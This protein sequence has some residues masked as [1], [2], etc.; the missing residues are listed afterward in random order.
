[1]DFIAVVVI[2][3]KLSLRAQK[4]GYP[5]YTAALGVVG[6]TFGQVVGF[7]FGAQV[8][9]ELGAMLTCYACAVL[10]AL[11][12]FALVNRLPDRSVVVRLD[13][14]DETFR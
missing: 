14:L 9:L 13:E 10:G 11:A 1:M 6:W 8:G 2:A 7:A 5:G 12:A 3:R 4:K